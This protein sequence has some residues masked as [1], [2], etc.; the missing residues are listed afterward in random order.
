[1][2]KKIKAEEHY[3]QL[4]GISNDKSFM[5][6]TGSFDIDPCSVPRPTPKRNFNHMSILIKSHDII[7]QLHSLLTLAFATLSLCQYPPT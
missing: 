3:Q 5:E 4:S 6:K 1:M 7:V 2:E